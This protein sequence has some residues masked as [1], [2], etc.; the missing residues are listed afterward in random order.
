MAFTGIPQAIS[1][2]LLGF[3]DNPYVILMVMY[4]PA[5]SLFLPELSGHVN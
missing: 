3:T 4:I 1:D 2:A 5:L